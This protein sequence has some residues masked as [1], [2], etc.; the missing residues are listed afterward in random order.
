MVKN[1]ELKEIKRVGVLSIGKISVLFGLIMGIIAATVI[2]VL[3]ISPAVDQTGLENL[4]IPTWGIALF[5][6]VYYPLASFLV[7]VISA[8]IYNGLTRFVG[9]VKVQL[10]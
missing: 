9:G 8:A 6:L 2:L 10:N 4:N 1:I 3:G 5:M 7:G